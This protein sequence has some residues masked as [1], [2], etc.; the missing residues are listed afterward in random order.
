MLNRVIKYED[1]MNRFRDIYFTLCWSI[2]CV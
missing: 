2:Q 1:E